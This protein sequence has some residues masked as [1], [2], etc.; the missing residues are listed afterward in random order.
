[1][2]VTGPTRPAF[3]AASQGGQ[4]PARLLRVDPG[5]PAGAGAARLGRPADRAQHAVQARRLGRDGRPHRRRGAR[6]PSPWSAISTTSPAM[7]LDRSGAWSTGSTSMRRPM[8]PPN[9]GPRCWP[10]SPDRRSGPSAGPGQAS[11]D[12]VDQPGRPGDDPLR[13][14]LRPAPRPPAGEAR[15]SASASSSVMSGGHLDAVPD[16]AVDLDDHGHRCPRPP[17][18]GRPPA[19][20]CRWMWSPWRRS[21]ASA[22]RCGVIGASSSNR[23]S[24]ASLDHL[25]VTAVR[26]RRAGGG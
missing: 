7:V 15:A 19:R 10:A 26:A 17:A 16:L 6:R 4:E 1:M 5:L 2:V 25:G 12:D 13:G 21:H 23:V 20:A 3:A 18:R 24:T 8:V 14:R 9:A 11:D 22:A